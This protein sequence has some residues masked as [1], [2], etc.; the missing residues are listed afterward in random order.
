MALLAG[1]CT[2]HPL[3][4]YYQQHVIILKE[5]YRIRHLLLK[6]LFRLEANKTYASTLSN[7]L[8][9]WLQLQQLEIQMV[10]RLI[11]KS[12]VCNPK[13]AEQGHL[14][15]KPAFLYAQSIICG[16][17]VPLRFACDPLFTAKS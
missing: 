14:P 17:C 1:V 4:W 2:L 6:R 7:L 16:F 12:L 13:F 11:C 9:K 3:L 10:A 5:A 8:P 15:N